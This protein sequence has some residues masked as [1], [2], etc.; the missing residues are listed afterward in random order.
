MRQF[1]DKQVKYIIYGAIGLATLLVVLIVLGLFLLFK[2]VSNSTNVI[3]T[4]YIEKKLE[5]NYRFID[6]LTKAEHTSLAKLSLIEDR[7]DSIKLA[8]V[9][10]DAKIVRLQTKIT[11]QD[12]AYKQTLNYLDTLS[13]DGY[14][15][16]FSKLYREYQNQ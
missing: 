1:N 13:S 8:V 9:A 14:E 12:E 10:K 11:L 15:L 3:Y 4:D 7:I 2:P 16:E 5:D 6:S